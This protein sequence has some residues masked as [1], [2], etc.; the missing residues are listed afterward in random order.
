MSAPVDQ[1]SRPS[2]DHSR[3]TGAAGSPAATT[4]SESEPGRP[5][6]EERGWLLVAVV[7]A[8]LV[9]AFGGMLVLTALAGG[10]N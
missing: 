1:P 5:G 10:T 6:L 3:D 4:P 9:L 7:V 2:G 8:F